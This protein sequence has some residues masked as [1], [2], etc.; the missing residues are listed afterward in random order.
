[1]TKKEIVESL[2]KSRELYNICRKI[3]TAKDT[4]DLLQ[5]VVLIL[6]SKDEEKICELYFNKQLKF[7]IIKIIQNQVNS[8]SSPFYTKFRKFSHISTNIDEIDLIEKNNDNDYRL[9][10]IDNEIFK[11]SFETKEDWYQSN[12]VKAYLKE[13]SLRNLS[14]KIKINKQSIRY[15]V[16]DFKK[17]I[18]T[19]DKQFVAFME[20]NVTCIKLSAE[21]KKIIFASA[22]KQ[23]LEPEKYIEKILTEK[24]KESGK[25]K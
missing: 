10:L 7:F 11:D 4:D 1:L 12:M 13:G 19:R 5:E 20:N 23:S 21:A 6:L 14:E 22:Q 16:N 3:C 25:A 2:Y 9:D 18:E 24:S 17:V 15:T 8:I